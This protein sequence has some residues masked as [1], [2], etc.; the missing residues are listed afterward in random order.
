MTWPASFTQLAHLQE[1]LAGKASGPFQTLT[2]DEAVGGVF[3][4]FTRGAGGIGQ[5]GDTGWAGAALT[6]D[7]QKCGTNP[8]G[9]TP[10]AQT[11][12]ARSR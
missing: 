9:F 3:A 5:E 8:A 10:G 4:C 12:E 7:G 1:F 6:Q 11:V 2:G